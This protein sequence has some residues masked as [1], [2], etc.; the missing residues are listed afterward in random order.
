MGECIVKKTPGTQ[1]DACADATP[2]ARSK[3]QC[4]DGTYTDD[5]EC[6]R[7]ACC[8]WQP[9]ADPGRRGLQATAFDGS[10]GGAMNCR[11]FKQMLVSRG[12]CS[13]TEPADGES[14][15][16][17]N[18]ISKMSYINPQEG[19]FYPLLSPYNKQIDTNSMDDSF[20]DRASIIRPLACTND[21]DCPESHYQEVCCKESSKLNYIKNAAFPIYAHLILVIIFIAGA[22]G[23]YA[24]FGKGEKGG[25]H[26]TV[27]K[28]VLISIAIALGVLTAWHI[29][30]GSRYSIKSAITHDNIEGKAY[31]VGDSEL[32]TQC[33][34]RQTCDDDCMPVPQSFNAANADTNYSN[35]GECQ[36][37]SKCQCKVGPDGIMELLYVMWH[38]T[39]I[40]KVGTILILLSILGV[41]G[42]GGYKIFDELFNN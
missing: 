32:N 25:E 3:A 34:G 30:D 14:D 27:I 33:S 9:P 20:N 15:C 2:A 26:I 28:W 7:N 24:I 1:N 42:L 10:S 23:I 6:N 17:P 12:T 29:S 4:T 40:A 16:C 31:W 11:Q 13:G 41:I 36:P 37:L 22:L 38:G 5:T 39:I 21:R 19:R 8:E 18:N 35:E